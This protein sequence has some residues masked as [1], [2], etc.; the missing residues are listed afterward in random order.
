MLDGRYMKDRVILYVLLLAVVLAF[1]VIVLLLPYE[2]IYV[3]ERIYLDVFL[4][5]IIICVA[6]FVLGVLLNALLWMRGKGLVGSP[7]GRMLRLLPK[8]ARFLLSRRVG[9][10]I[11]IFAKDALYLS[12]LKD[13]SATRWLMHLLILGGF[14]ATFVLDLVVT[15]S[16][17]IV[18]YRPMIEEQGWAKIW[19][20]DF[21]FDLAGFLMLLGLLIAAVRRFIFKP[22]IVRT[23]LPDAMSIL[24]LLAVVVGGFF[25][26][27]VGISGAIEGHQANE[28]YSFVGYAFAAVTPASWGQYYD[29]IWLLHGVMSALLIAYIPFSKM[30]HMIATPI[31]IEVDRML[32]REGVTR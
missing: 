16:L 23:E 19:I 4:A 10:A 3:K 9:K 13:R 29:E 21:A 32:P 28:V 5:T 18:K 24:F 31:A 12:K 30:F 27:G 22:K 20:R 26:E 17:D 2:T 11:S 25:L 8:T 7:E 1:S 15:F 14:V 6:V